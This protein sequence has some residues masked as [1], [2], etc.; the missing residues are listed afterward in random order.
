MASTSWRGRGYARTA[1]PYYMSGPPSM[2]NSQMIPMVAIGRTRGVEALPLSAAEPLSRVR[3]GLLLFAVALGLRLAWVLTLSDTLTW[4]DERQFADIARHIVA[5]HGYVSDSFR[6]NPI[7]PAYLS[8]N[9]WLWGEHY[10]IPRIGTA[11]LSAATCVLISRITAAGAGER[12]GLLAGV[13]S[14]LYLPHIYLAGVFYVDT[15]LTFVLAAAVYLV[16]RA[17]DTGR[18]SL[19]IASGV[20]LGLTILT[21]SIYIVYVPC[22]LA[23][24]MVRG[25]GDRG[26]ALRRCAIL[27]AAFALT[28]LP[29]TVRNYRTYGRVMLVSSGFGTKLWEGNNPLSRGTADDR[30]LR[31]DSPESIARVAQLPAEEQA[32]F[33]ARYGEVSQR[34]AARRRVTGDEMLALDD[35]LLPVALRYM[36]DHPGRTVRLFVRKLVTL[37]SAF[38]ETQSENEVTTRRNKLL[39]AISFYPVLLLALIGATMTG[40]RS[41]LRPVVLLIASTSLTYALLDTCTRFRLPLDPFLIVFASLP[42]SWAWS[43]LADAVPTPG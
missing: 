35:V 41:R 22:V 4:I 16:M 2:T 30:D 12:A 23:L 31:W 8:L 34:V 7:L 24:W 6:A 14:A 13:L 38:T 37:Y 21:R 18:I 43:R 25:R 9:F 17:G 28:V 19:A 36:A 27:V 42:L 20:A 1:D 33:R 3:A 11:L 39:A 29:W 5:G 26:A 32:E 15:M 40:A 10:V